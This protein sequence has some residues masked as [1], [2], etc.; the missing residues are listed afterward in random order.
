MAIGPVENTEMSGPNVY[1]IAIAAAKEA[2]RLNDVRTKRSKDGAL[3]EK[4]IGLK[5]TVEA[6][7]RIM[8]GKAKVVYPSNRGRRSRVE[9]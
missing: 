2:R 8:E 5:V 6:L 4:E 7:Q 3:E 1:E 9:R